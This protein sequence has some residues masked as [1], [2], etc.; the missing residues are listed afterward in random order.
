MNEEQI[1]KFQKVVKYGA[2]ALAVLLII[3]IFY[4]ILTG[5]LAVFGVSNA[6]GETKSFTVEG[7]IQSLDLEI[8]AAE[9]KITEG[10]S[11]SVKSNLKKLDVDVQSGTLNIKNKNKG[12]FEIFGGSNYNGAVLEIVIPK[13]FE[14]ENADI[15]IGAGV[16][17]IEKFSVQNLEFDLGA[18]T[19]TVKKLIAS[20]ESRINNGAGKLKIQGGVLNNLDFDMG[21]GET[22]IRVELHGSADVDIDVGKLTLVLIG[23]ESDY[24]IDFSKG[25]GS[26]SYNGNNVENNQ[27][28]G[29][30]SVRIDV[31]G[32][33]GSIDVKTQAQ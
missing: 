21:T 17:E 16:V 4:G 23:E 20:A 22:E 18:G 31:D 2:I 26:I 7:E 1:K 25:L 27:V 30:G 3:S 14:F 5:I 11:F 28:I 12:V 13:D 6:V 9:L 33:M 8:S 10:T 32:G 29:N 19:V 24:K 15:E